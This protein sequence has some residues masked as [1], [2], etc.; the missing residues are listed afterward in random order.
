MAYHADDGKCYME[1]TSFAYSARYGTGDVI[2]CG[3]TADK[4]IYF[5]IN[6][7]LL[8]QISC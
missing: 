7:V 4:N 5:T 8:P 3:V 1:G 6:G 2:G